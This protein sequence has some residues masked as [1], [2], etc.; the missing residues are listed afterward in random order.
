MAKETSHLDEP[1]RQTR[2][3]R[4][5]EGEKREND[6]MVQEYIS[7]LPDSKNLEHSLTGTCGMTVI[8]FAARYLIENKSWLELARDSS[9][10]MDE[11]IAGLQMIYTAF[12]DKKISY[13]SK[14]AALSLGINMFP[15]SEITTEQQMM[16]TFI[17][18]LPNGIYSSHSKQEILRTPFCSPR[19]ERVIIDP[20][21]G[22]LANQ[23]M[24]AF[25]LFARVIACYPLPE[26]RTHHA[27]EANRFEI[28]PPDDQLPWKRIFLERA[29]SIG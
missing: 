22:L 27:L 11:R 9:E 13:F 25:S 12:Y 15:V 2:I 24:Q 7:S 29:I 16:P 4:F 17:L 18:N 23:R 26:N 3:N 19:N 21:I 10:G 5:L 8:D 28:A 20:N 1:I 14:L 6:H